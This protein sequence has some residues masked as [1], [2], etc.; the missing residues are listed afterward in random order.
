MN[1]NAFRLQLLRRFA[2]SGSPLEGAFELTGRCNLNC[3]MCY[4]HTKTNKEFLATEKDGDWWISQIDAACERGMLFALLTGGECMLHPDFRRIYLHLQK[5]GVYVR[6]NTNGL[7][8]TEENI[9]FLKQNPPF[10]IQLTIYGFDEES[11]EKVT[12]FSAFNRIEEA[13]LRAKEAGLNLR[14]AITPNC[15]L[16]GGTEKIIKYLKRL[17]VPF[18]VN[19]AMFTPYDESG[20][21]LISGKE[22]EIEERIGYLRLLKNGEPKTVD[23]GNLPPVGGNR[24]PSGPIARCSAGRISFVI[25]HDGNMVPCT[26]MYHLRVPLNSAEDFGPAWERMQDIGKNFLV[27]IECEGCAYRKACL[28][29]PILRGGKVGNGHCDPAVCEMTRKLVAAG[30]KK[31]DIAEQGCE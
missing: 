10:E 3:K 7:L 28:S 12:G 6:I 21:Q 19:E 29:C 9:A 16:P 4:V 26:S 20:P 27:P 30:V 24:K 18:S 25:T 17:D 15:Y 22:V 23:E 11:Y 31:L 8:L 14:V 5:K 13:I 2:N 1:Q